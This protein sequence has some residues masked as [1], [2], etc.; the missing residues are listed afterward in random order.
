MYRHAVADIGGD[1]HS[2]IQLFVVVRTTKTTVLQPLC[3][4]TYVS[5]CRQL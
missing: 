4:S 2:I 1:R 3:R 5:R